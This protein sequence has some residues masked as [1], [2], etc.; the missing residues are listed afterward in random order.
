MAPLAGKLADRVS[1]ARLCAI[2]GGALAAGLTLCALWPVQS[3]PRPALVSFTVIAGAGFGLF[4][5]PN[6]RNMLLSAPK[7][8]SG[9]AGGAQGMARLTGQTMGSLLMGL[10]FSALPAASASHVGLGVAAGFALA[11]GLISLMRGET[12]RS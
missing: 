3:D 12:Q 5:T 6:N 8:R 2:G 7:D 1:T 10:L 11:A 4:Q 9:A